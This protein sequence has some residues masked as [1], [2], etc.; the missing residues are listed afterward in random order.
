MSDYSHGGYQYNHRP[1]QKPTYHDPTVWTAPEDPYNFGWIPSNNNAGTCGF[2]ENS[3]ELAYPQTASLNMTGYQPDGQ[4][5]PNNLDGGH[6]MSFDSWQQTY[7]YPMHWQPTSWQQP[8]LQ[9]QLSWLQ[10][11]VDT[12]LVVYNDT[13]ETGRMQSLDSRNH[14]RHDDEIPQSRIVASTSVPAISDPSQSDMVT[15]RPCHDLWKDVDTR[16]KQ[17]L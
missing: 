4:L 16:T 17:R 3:Y 11:V 1:P 13:V 12:S 6:S 10:T 7:W 5:W 2:D 14:P 8:S 9:Q 15:S